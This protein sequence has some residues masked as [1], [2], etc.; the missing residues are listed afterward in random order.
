M[1]FRPE[2]VHATSGTGK[3]LEPPP[4]GH[5]HIPDHTLGFYPQNDSIPNLHLYALSTIEAWGIDANRFAGK[6]PADR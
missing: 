4:K 1:L 5:G 6:K 2:E 3:I